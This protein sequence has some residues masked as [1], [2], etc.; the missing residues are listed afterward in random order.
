MHLELKAVRVPV[1]RTASHKG[2]NTA[3]AGLGGAVPSR[4][5]PQGPA[6]RYCF[7]RGGE[8]AA[9]NGA[10]SSDGHAPWHSFI[11]S[12]SPKAPAG[13][14][15]PQVSGAALGTPGAHGLLEPA[16]PQNGLLTSKYGLL[17]TEGRQ[18]N[19]F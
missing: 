2:C 8:G 1:A 12:P 11:P 14:H 18:H 7:P 9:L 15:G 17:L 5:P 19:V 3:A 10:A 16:A 4:P 6:R 13:T